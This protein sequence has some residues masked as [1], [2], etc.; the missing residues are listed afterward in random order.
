[1]TSQ[2]SRKIEG[3]GNNFTY[4]PKSRYHLR[5]S[6]FQMIMRATRGMKMFL[7]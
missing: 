2:G 6:S 3:F 1:L 4:S 5:N 7:F